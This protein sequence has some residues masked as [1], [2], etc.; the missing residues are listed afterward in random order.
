MAQFEEILHYG[1]ILND[2]SREGSRGHCTIGRQRVYPLAR[3]ILRKLR[4]TL[5]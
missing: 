2:F 3:R 5:M 1:V 4:M